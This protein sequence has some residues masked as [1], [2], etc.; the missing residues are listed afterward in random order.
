MGTANGNRKIAWEDRFNEPS[1]EALRATLTEG[2][3]KFFDEIREQLAATDGVREQLAWYGECWRWSVEYRIDD[4]EE[5]LAVLI[6]APEDLQVAV[7][8]ERELAE[9]LGN[10]SLKRTI[11]DGL[12]LAQPPFDTRWGVWSIQHPGV[13]KDLKGLIDRKLKHTRGEKT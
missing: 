11:R 12:E 3:T 2:A 1:P 7:P 13:W 9:Q 6:P 10:K 5:P 8:F 4:D